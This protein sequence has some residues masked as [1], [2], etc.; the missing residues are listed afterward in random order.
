MIFLWLSIVKVFT[1]AAFCFF[2]SYFRPLLLWIQSF[3]PLWAGDSLK[4]CHE[5]LPNDIWN[6]W[7]EQML[8]LGMSLGIGYHI[9]TDRIVFTACPAQLTTKLTLSTGHLLGFFHIRCTISKKHLFLFSLDLTK[10]YCNDLKRCCFVEV[11]WYFLLF[12]SK[13]TTEI[14]QRLPYKL[15]CSI[16]WGW[17]T[18]ITINRLK[19]VSLSS[20]PW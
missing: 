17:L 1:I 19:Q 9:S 16:H 14:W 8:L 3:E 20:D 12:H 13:Y 11:C 10:C 18:V 5:F 15:Q 2:L 6:P 7:H 4:P